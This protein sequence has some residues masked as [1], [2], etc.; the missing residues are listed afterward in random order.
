MGS[1]TEFSNMRS[2][3]IINICGY[4]YDFVDVLGYGDCLFS[5]LIQD[6]SILTHLNTIGVLCGYMTTNVKERYT[7]DSIL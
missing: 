5:I 1:G 6:P 4:H 2:S 3:Y 7:M